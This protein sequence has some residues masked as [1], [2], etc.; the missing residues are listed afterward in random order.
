MVET[1]APKAASRVTYNRPKVETLE[2]RR[3][4]PMRSKGSELENNDQ[5]F[6]KMTKMI[7]RV[8][9]SLEIYLYLEKIFI[10]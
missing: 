6:E 4:V 7:I 1:L 5:D 8:H 3:W 9:F 10:F 2:S